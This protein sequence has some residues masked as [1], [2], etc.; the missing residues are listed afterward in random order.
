M[1]PMGTPQQEQSD[2]RHGSSNEDCMLPFF[3]NKNEIMRKFLVVPLVLNYNTVILQAM[4][5]RQ[6]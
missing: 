6:Q 3:L 1:R 4:E 5:W 2:R